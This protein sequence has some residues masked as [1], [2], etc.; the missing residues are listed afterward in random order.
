MNIKIVNYYEDIVKLCRDASKLND[1]AYNIDVYVASENN[2]Y[3]L[4]YSRCANKYL[5]LFSN[6]SDLYWRYMNNY[7]KTRFKFG[8]AELYFRQY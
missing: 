8:E 2:W 4:Y 5:H 1:M 3:Y 6:I 7:F